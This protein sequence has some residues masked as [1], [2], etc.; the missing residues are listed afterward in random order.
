MITMNWIPISLNWTILFKCLE[1]TS[2]VIWRYINKLNW[3]ELNWCSADGGS[4][5]HR[6]QPLPPSTMHQSGLSSPDSSSAYG[7][8]SNRHSF[9]SYSDSFMSSAAPS[10]HVNPVSN[11]LSPQVRHCQGL[12]WPW[13]MSMCWFSIVIN[14]TQS[15]SLP[16]TDLCSVKIKKNVSQI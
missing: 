6:P 16:H 9:S 5:V 2:V 3:T 15:L 14:E 1:M 8:S 11:G 12:S 7:L 13:C 4:T 10:N